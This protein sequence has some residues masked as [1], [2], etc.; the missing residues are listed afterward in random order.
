MQLVVLMMMIHCFC[1]MAERK[2]LNL[3]SRRNDCQTSSLLQT[4]NTLRAGSEPDR[5]K[6]SC[7]IELSR[8][9]GIVPTPRLHRQE[10]G[11]RGMSSEI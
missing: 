4:S 5:K 2:A 6:S 10:S 1:G 8:E 3:I 7:I 9:I 11:N